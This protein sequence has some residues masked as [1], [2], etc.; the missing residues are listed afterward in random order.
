MA[1]ITA[2]LVVLTPTGEPV[3]NAL[4]LAWCDTSSETMNCIEAI[5]QT[6]T[7]ELTPAAGPACEAVLTVA[8]YC[9]PL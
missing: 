8:P 9:G 7:A 2:F 4:C 5:A 6:T 3:I 1:S